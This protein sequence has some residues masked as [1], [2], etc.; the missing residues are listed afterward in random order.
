MI[1][2]AAKSYKVFCQLVKILQVFQKHED[3]AGRIRYSMPRRINPKLLN[4]FRPRTEQGFLIRV[5]PLRLFRQ[6]KRFEMRIPYEVW[7]PWGSLSGEARDDFAWADVVPN[8]L[9]ELNVLSVRAIY[10]NMTGF[11]G[12]VHEVCELDG[13]PIDESELILYWDLLIYEGKDD[14]DLEIEK[15]E[16]HTELRELWNKHCTHWLK[17]NG[18]T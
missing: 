15:N 12:W 7:T 9:T 4:P 16:D 5:Q 3:S 17:K 2:K 11:D 8:I 18:Y 13:R 6:S 1:S 10:S 14:R